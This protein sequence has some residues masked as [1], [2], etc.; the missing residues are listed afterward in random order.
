MVFLVKKV[1]KRRTNKINKLAR[2]K[3]LYLRQHAGNPVAWWPWSEEVLKE[4]Q[5]RDVPLFISIG[6]S[7]CHWCHVM[8]RESFEDE[9]I[10][11]LLNENFLPVK[12]DREEHPEI[13]AVYLLACE[14]ATGRAG[15]PLTVLALPDGWPFFV[16]TYLPKEGSGTRLGLKELLKLVKKLWREDRRRL[17]EAAQNFKKALAQIAFRREA[18]VEPALLLERAFE[19]AQRQFDPQFGGFGKGPKFPLATRLLFLLRYGKRLADAK[20]LDMV[21]FTLLKMR[22]SALF[23]QVGFGFHRYTVDR[24]WKVP[25]FEKMLYD[26]GLLLYLYAEAAALLNE[27]IFEKTAEEIVTYLKERLRSPSGSFF[28]AESAESAEKEGLFYTWSLKEIEENLSRQ[29]AEILIKYFSLK[30]EGNYLEEATGQPAGRNVLH[31]VD[32]PWLW[33]QKENFNGFEKLLSSILLKLKKIRAQRP[34]PPRD[35]KILTDWNGL[36]IAGLAHAGRLLNRPD[37]ISLAEE[38]FAYLE[39]KALWRG[40]LLHLPETNLKGLLEDYVYFTW[41][42]RELWEATEAGKYLKLFYTLLDETEKL[43]SSGEHLYHQVGK[44]Q[45][46]FLI[47]FY[48]VFEGALPS[49]NGLLALLFKQAGK[50]EAS[51]RIISAVGGYLLEDPFSFPSFMMVFV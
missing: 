47:P 51:E 10:A 33:A 20:A 24:A 38:A 39:Q 31:P 34:Y 30:P 40:R 45:K 49:P 46:P 6:Y 29:E 4:G 37:F 11:G 32:F 50:D 44:D 21:R 19:G 7:A 43:F 2:E 35:E 36:V 9:E 41:A 3:S 26:Q 16:A 8:N 23:D 25:H 1:F 48:P 22:F 27:P 14:M 12:I 18:T 28:C 13:D 5:R 42:A 15:W 17:L